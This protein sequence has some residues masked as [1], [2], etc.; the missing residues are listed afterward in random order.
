[1]E[2]K[3]DHMFRSLI[4]L[5]VLIS[6]GIFSME[7]SL[8]DVEPNGS[9]EDPEEIE[10]GRISGNVTSKY[11]LVGDEYIEDVDNDIYV[12]TVPGMTNLTVELKKTDNYTDSIRIRSYGEDSIQR[13][14]IH[15]NVYIQGEVSR[16]V[17]TN[18]DIN[19][20][21]VKMVVSGNGTY[22]IN[23]E[24]D[25]I[26]EGY[27]KRWEKPPPEEDREQT[28]YFY[29]TA[30]RVEP[31]VYNGSVSDGYSPFPRDQYYRIT[32]PKGKSLKIDLEKTDDNE[33]HIYLKTYLRGEYLGGPD[34]IMLDVNLERRTD[35]GYWENM[36]ND[37]RLVIFNVEGRGNYTMEVD[38]ADFDR[39]DP[40]LW[41]LIFLVIIVVGT[42]ISLF[43]P[44]L[45]ILVIIIFIVKANP[46]SKKKKKRKKKRS[47][48]PG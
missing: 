38:I 13:N 8:A 33:G 44:L 27:L 18:E 14:M 2:G 20:T 45:I 15:V 23:V 26:P 7:S 46:S 39:V 12:V 29:E 19:G 34:D 28:H 16:D 37:D 48:N 41:I 22:E 30:R 17:F 4:M 36:E 42:I 6:M 25:D 5:L 31:G 43:I 40:G 10:Q 32:V 3:R 24:I 21:V 9:L 35:S 47:S 1:M 11:Y